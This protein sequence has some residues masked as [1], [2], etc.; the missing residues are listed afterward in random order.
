MLLVGCILAFGFAVAPRIFLVLAW[1][2]STRWDLVWKGDWLVP[3]LGIIVLPYTTI[4][5]MLVY[6]PTGIQGWDWMWIAL[7]VLLDIM[8]WTQIANNRKGIPGYPSGEPVPATPST[9]P[10]PPP[11]P[12]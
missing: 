11:S 9:P 12:S 3:L 10:P 6:S 1:I 7:G 4:M 5:Y 8:K 2:F